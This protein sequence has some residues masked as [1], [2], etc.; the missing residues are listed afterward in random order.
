MPRTLTL[1]RF[2]ALLLFIFVILNLYFL[3][4]H[5]PSTLLSR[6]TSS[7]TTCYHLVFAVA[8]SRSW[9]RREPYL[10]LWCFPTSTFAFA[11]LD[12]VPIDFFGEK[13]IAP[14]VVSSDTSF[15]V[16]RRVMMIEEKDDGVG[17]KGGW[18]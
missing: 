17:L 8:S 13:S 14:V 11:F 7:P 15:A 5:T 6:Y 3:F 1:A 12:R 4:L 9:S 2:K 10:I 18:R 16:A